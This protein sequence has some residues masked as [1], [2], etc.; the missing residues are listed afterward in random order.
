VV[1]RPQ[2]EPEQNPP[3][4]APHA[5]GLARRD[6]RVKPQRFGRRKKTGTR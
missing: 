6:R 2:D 3:P 5:S 4:C 1:A